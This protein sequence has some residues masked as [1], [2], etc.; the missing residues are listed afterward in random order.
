MNRRTLLKSS[1]LGAGLGLAKVTG[2]LPDI[3]LVGAAPNGSTA[4]TPVVDTTSGK[5]RG[6]LHG[7]VNTFRGIPYGASTAGANRFLPPK[8]VEPWTGVRDAF[9]N[10]HSSPQVA[11]APGAIGAGLRGYAAQGEDCLV[12][13]VF[14]NGVSASGDA[15]KRPVMMWI[16]GGGYAYGSGSSLGYDGGNLARTGDVV[17]ACINHRL[18]IVGH[19]FLGHAGSVIEDSGNAGMLDRVAPLQRAPDNIANLCTD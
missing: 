5:V 1:L 3:T 15:K 13:N 7:G 2:G 6:V 14:T 16:H 19:L 11:P 12:L 18:N 17:V 9:Q 4:M 10:G 8:K